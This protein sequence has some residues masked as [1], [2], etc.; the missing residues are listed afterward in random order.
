MRFVI[1]ALAIPV[2]YS[3]IDDRIIK[4]VTSSLKNRSPTSQTFH[5]HHK[6]SL[7]SVINIDVACTVWEVKT[8]FT[9][10]SL[11]FRYK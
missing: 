5:R 6:L 2:V 4:L 1:F 8:G 10:F 9:K 7:K 3:Y 11:D